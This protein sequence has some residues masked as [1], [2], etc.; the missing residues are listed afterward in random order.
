M[1]LLDSR[2][3]DCAGAAALG[4]K[5]SSVPALCLQVGLRAACK[6]LWTVR[7][8]RG[9]TLRRRARRIEDTCGGLPFREGQL[10][11]SALAGDD[12]KVK[13][14]NMVRGQIGS[15]SESPSVQPTACARLCRNAAHLLCRLPPKVGL[16]M[17]GGTF[18]ADPLAQRAFRE[19]KAGMSGHQSR[20]Y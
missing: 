14:S 5:Q 16:T 20:I 13:A 18:S 2:N 12:T 9:R 1:H 17:L 11:L 7:R 10:T 8:R 19:A 4:M 6:M 3:L 15:R